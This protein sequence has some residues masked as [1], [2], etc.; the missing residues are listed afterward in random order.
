M[1]DRGR[2]SPDAIGDS[3]NSLGD[4]LSLTNTEFLKNGIDTAPPTRSS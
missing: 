3:V 2:S 4:D 1:D